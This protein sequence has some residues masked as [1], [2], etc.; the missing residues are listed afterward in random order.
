M[1]IPVS[2]DAF[3]WARAQLVVEREG[4]DALCTIATPNRLE[5]TVRSSEPVLTNDYCLFAR[6]DS[7]LFS[8]LKAATSIEDLLKLNPRVITYLGSGWS[9]AHLVGFEMEIVGNLD[10]VMRML[11]ARRADILIDGRVNIRHWLATHASEE[12][13][14][15]VTMLPTVYDTTR[16]DLLVRKKSEHLA[17][18]PEF[19]ARMKAFR[20]TPAYRRM[21]QAYGA[22]NSSKT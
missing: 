12:G 8:Q 13:A 15:E 3:P 17:W 18:L 20:K 22:E 14:S 9:T 2:F 4:Y 19:N 6:K 10:N 16:F 7:P 1:G 21:L 5:Y 11:I